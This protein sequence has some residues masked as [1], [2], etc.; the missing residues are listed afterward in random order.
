M[1]QHV[2]L[3]RAISYKADLER[4]ERVA[5]QSLSAV[6]VEK[7]QIEQ[8]LELYAHFESLPDMRQP[9]A[10]PE[11]IQESPPETTPPAKTESD[12]RLGDDVGGQP[13]QP[14]TATK[15]TG[16][17]EGSAGE[18][19]Q[20]GDALAGIAQAV[21][22][23]Q[24]TVE[25][26]SLDSRATGGSARIRVPKEP[27][28][29]PGPVDTISPETATET[30]AADLRA[31]DAPTSGSA[32]HEDA[33]TAAPGPSALD[34]VR[35]SLLKQLGARP[36]KTDAR[37][38]QKYSEPVAG[39]DVSAE[40]ASPPAPF[41]SKTVSAVNATPK[42][43]D[44]VI[45]LNT[46]HPEW[47]LSEVA[48]KLNVGTGSVSNAVSGRGIVF[49][50]GAKGQAPRNGTAGRVEAYLDAHP[51][52]TTSEIAAALGIQKS[53]VRTA[54]QTRGLTIRRMT[55]EERSA[56]QRAGQQGAVEKGTYRTRTPS[57][58]PK[59]PPT[60][61]S[62]ARAP[63]P[64]PIPAPA[65]APEPAPAAEPAIE[66]AVESR[67]RKYGERPAY[68]VGDPDAEGEAIDATPDLVVAP[69]YR[70]MS[71]SGQWLHRDM[72]RTTY[73]IADAWQG[74]ARDME[75]L[76]KASPRLAVYEAMK[77]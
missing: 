52:A 37:Y 29:K 1:T 73:K 66:D 56:V 54:A 26:T 39:A 10:Q 23:A 32:T 62:E 57:K 65:P 17:T 69:V 6:R 60:I 45:A 4:R 28:L 22:S 44:R 76:F 33:G 51:D 40:K 38:D 48:K 3:T 47:S 68:E 72:E 14:E 11:P 27:V 63:V 24:P 13:L 71:P 35:S 34:H 19:P 64:V 7:A 55:T 77:A 36:D 41:P 8:F 67:A 49:A 25:E 31:A 5:L 42:L 20:Y 18:K 16:S 30:G 15:S 21:K 2:V 50:R 43:R 75:R 46:E 58:A 12:R 74:N 53:S 59:Q 9:P 61:P 70:L